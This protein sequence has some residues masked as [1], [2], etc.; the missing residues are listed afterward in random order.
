MR[1]AIR[2]D[3]SVEMGVGHVQ[4]SVSLAQALRARRAQISFVTRDLGFG[5][6]AIMHEQGFEDVR[7][8]P[9]SENGSNRDGEPL[10]S[11][12]SD[13]PHGDWARVDQRDDAAQT[14]AALAQEAPDWVVIDSYSF[15]ARWHETV[16]L[17]LGCRIA[18]I[19]DLAD[20]QLSPDLLI[21]HNLHEDHR[22]KY[23]NVIDRESR[24]L[25]GPRFGLLAPAY[26]TSPKYTYSPK[27]R[28]I[29]IFMGGGD[30][31]NFSER[32]FDAV[33]ASRFSGEIE[34]VLNSANSHLARLRERVE[35]RRGAFIS[36]DLPDLAGFFARHD[37]QIGAGGGATWERCCIGVPSV[38]VITADNQNVVIPQ[39]VARDIAAAPDAP[40][41]G[42]VART[43]R[44]LIDNP[45]RR[46][47][48]AENA[49]ATVDGF[50]AARVAVAMLA[51]TLVVRPAVLADVQN[52]FDWRN[53]PDNRTMM[54]NADAMEYADHCAWLDRV[55]AD[56]NRRLF[57]GE[58]GGEPVGSIRFD[59]VNGTAEVSLHLDPNFHGLGLGPKLLSAGEAASGAV[60][61]I[62]KVLD[63]NRP[64]KLLFARSGYTRIGS[65]NW[66]KDTV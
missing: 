55:L 51:E 59:I 10:T 28:S 64:S 48:L 58:V 23:A 38:L 6:A 52:L 16:R 7:V 4:R 22:M 1:V 37:L 45:A 24:L 12:P 44:R 11:C 54:T 39:I 17:G 27:V 19:D 43:V 66:R 35:A 33:L 18:V 30:A 25:D 14:I 65:E 15:D 62:A 57:V 41:V 26:V 50:G 29:G 46:R 5:S 63:K 61:F 53:A 2:V 49:R 32:M 36:T 42:A 31:R 13:I 34:I 47:E 8:L 40:T 9:A 60:S 20:R 21:D 3:A 56:E